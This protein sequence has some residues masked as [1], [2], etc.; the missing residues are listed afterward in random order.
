MSKGVLKQPILYLSDF[1]ERNRTLYYDNLMRVRTHNDMNQWLK[2]FL[3]GV[4]ETSKKGVATFDGILQLQKVLEEKLKTLGNRNV[5]ARK[6]IDYLY[7]QPII[8]VNKVEELIE[9][10]SVTSYKLLSDLEKLDIIK[11]ISGAQRNRLYVF[12][13][14][15][16]LFNND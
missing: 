13:D 12:K 9:K 6:I 15:I 1:F 8:E 4:I 5:D 11:E 7:S 14:Y 3:T 2:F 16:D 10:S